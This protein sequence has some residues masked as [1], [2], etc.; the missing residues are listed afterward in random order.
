MSASRALRGSVLRVV[1]KYGLLILLVVLFVGF[2]LLRPDTFPTLFNIRAIL[3]DKSVVA[4][5][6]LGLMVPLA[7]NQFDLSVGSIVTISHL[8]VIGLQ[9]WNGVPPAVA[10]AISLLVG[11]GIGLVNGLL[12]TRAQL[13]SFIATLGTG[14]VLIGIAMWYSQGVQVVG[15]LPE[16]F[17]F[18]A[19]TLAGVPIAAI[20]VAVCAIGLWLFFEYLPGGRSIYAI[21]ANARSAQLVA[22]PVE[23]TVVFAFIVSGVLSATAGVLLASRLRIGQASIGPEFLLPAF[24]AALLGATA[25]R[26]GR[27]N[28]IGTILAVAILAVAVAGLQQFGVQFFVEPLFNGMMLI[29]AVGLSGYAARRRAHTQDSSLASSHPADGATAGEPASR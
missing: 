5:V 28:A 14:T 10:V 9:V 7:A 22:I 20:V 2:S 8:L 6:A 4:L 21:G 17:L 3:S 12:V 1:S 27:V 25:I 16:A 11:A 15:D 13:S 19:S 24:T 26:P 18:L 29:L 23:R